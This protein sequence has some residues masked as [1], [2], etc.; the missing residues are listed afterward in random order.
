MKNKSKVNDGRLVLNYKRTFIIGFAFFGIL[1]LWQVY[2]TYVPAILTQLLMQQ[3]GQAEHEVQYLVG[4]LMALDNILALF[5]LPLF[6]YLSDRTK[7]KLGKRMPYIIVGTV[8]SAIALIG[9]PIAYAYDSLIGFIITMGLVLIFMQAYRNPAVALMPDITPKP[10]RSKANGIIN[11]VGYVGAILAGVI[12]MVITPEDY[13][14]ISKGNFMMYLPF[15]IAALCMLI[16]MIVLAVTTNENKILLEM[17]DDL[18]RGELEAEVEEPL[19]EEQKLSKKNRTALILLIV[20]IFLWFA[21][22]NAVET[23]WSNYSTYYLNFA[24]FSMGIIVLTV[25]SLITFV[26]ASMLADK[27]GRKW[28]I[29]IGLGL[30]ILAM[31]GVF[32]I[33]PIFT[34]VFVVEGAFA[35]IYYVFFAVAG[36]GWAMINCCSYPMVVELSTSKSIGKFTGIYYASSMLAQSLTPVALGALIGIENFQW[37][38]MFPYST[39]LFAAALVVFFFVPNIRSKKT[40]T[41]KGLEVFDQD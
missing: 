35:F 38:V 20:A 26:P 24:K 2:N 3:L 11:L 37:A 34:D 40:N 8:L 7:T 14:V 25:V 1:M 18:A 19:H 5:M 32:F 9:L 15:I 23:F 36:A 29:I 21:A 27:I 31:L 4:V 30:M 28:T 17:K 6:G 16:T 10:L 39:I 13:F 33:G 12:A 41:K 22:F